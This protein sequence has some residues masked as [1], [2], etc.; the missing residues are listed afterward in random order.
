MR[1][2]WSGQQVQSFNSD[3]VSWGALGNLLYAP[4]GRYAV[5]VSFCLSGYIF[6]SLTRGCIPIKRLYRSQF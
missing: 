2:Q 6:S 4:D 5:R 3:A 1:Q